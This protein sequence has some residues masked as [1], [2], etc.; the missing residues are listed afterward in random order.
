MFN[1]T[2]TTALIILLVA[3]ILIF[4]LGKWNVHLA[5]WAAFILTLISAIFVVL[6]APQIINGEVHNEWSTTLLQGD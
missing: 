3:P 1:F 6:V 4:L 5:K 2:L